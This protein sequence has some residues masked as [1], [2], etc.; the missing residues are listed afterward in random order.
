MSIRAIYNHILFKFVDKVNTQGQFEEGTTSSG[1]IL[2]ANTDDSAKKPRWA[3]IVSIGPDCSE[4]FNDPNIEILVDNLKWTP[5][6]KH[7]GELIWRTDED[8]VLGYRYKEEK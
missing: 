8:Q 6:V 2:Q 4:I 3:T 7:N 1:I 5:G